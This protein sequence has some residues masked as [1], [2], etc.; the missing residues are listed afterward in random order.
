VPFE[1]GFGTIISERVADLVMLFV[2]ILI[3]LFLEFEFI[4]NFFIERFDPYKIVIV[5][6]ANSYCWNFSFT[7]L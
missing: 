5:V 3:A 7:F 1:K 4:Y 2:I 6:F